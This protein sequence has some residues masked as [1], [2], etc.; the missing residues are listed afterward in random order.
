[1]TLRRAAL[2]L[3]LLA[4]LTGAAMWGVARLDGV[5]TGAGSSGSPGP[6]AAAP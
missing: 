3:G 2:V 1:M 4:A 5:E 6:V